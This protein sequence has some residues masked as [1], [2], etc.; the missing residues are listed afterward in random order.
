VTTLP[1]DYDPTSRE[2]AMRMTNEGPDMITTGVLFAIQH[3]TLVDEMAE[4]KTKAAARANT[5]TEML[6]AFA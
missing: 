6:A 1:H 5:R 3:P 2:G 4:I